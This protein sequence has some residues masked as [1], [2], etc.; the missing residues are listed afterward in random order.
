MKAIINLTTIAELPC[1]IAYTT[2][3]HVSFKIGREIATSDTLN[4]L[5]EMGDV[6]IYG[7]SDYVSVTLSRCFVESIVYVD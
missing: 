1:K 3:G 2:K 5:N 6:S 7:Y 4:A